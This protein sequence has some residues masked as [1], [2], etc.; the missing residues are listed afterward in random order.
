MRRTVGL[1]LVWVLLAGIPAWA[2]EFPEYTPERQKLVFELL[3]ACLKDG[4]LNLAPTPDGKGQ[5]LQVVDREKVRATLAGRR[6]R[7]T[8]ELR[9]A[10]L[11]FWGRSNE[12]SGPAVV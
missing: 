12:A 8:A 6:E 9:D 11:A 4:G 7:L 10:L 2:Q 5:F 3:G 1:A